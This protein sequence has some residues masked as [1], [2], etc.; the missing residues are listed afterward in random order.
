MQSVTDRAKAG[1]SEQKEL[2]LNHAN[3]TVCSW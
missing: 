2:E 3:S 1:G